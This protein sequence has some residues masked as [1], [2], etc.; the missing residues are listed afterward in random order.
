LGQNDD[1]TYTVMSKNSGKALALDIANCGLADGTPVGEWT[2]LGNDC[3]KWSF[4]RR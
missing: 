1:G 3:Q 4:R 2:A